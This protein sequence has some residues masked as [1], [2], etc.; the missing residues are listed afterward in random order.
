[1]KFSED[2]QSSIK[3]ITDDLISKWKNQHGIDLILTARF[4]HMH[5]L[6]FIILIGTT[7]GIDGF[8][9]TSLWIGSWYYR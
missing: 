2:Q 8:S 6:L 7:N 9:V 1:V 5:S 3:E 4:G